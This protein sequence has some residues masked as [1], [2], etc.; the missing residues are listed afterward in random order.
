[1]LHLCMETEK[2]EGTQLTPLNRS[3][4]ESKASVS[5]QETVSMTWPDHREPFLVQLLGNTSFIASFHG[6]VCSSLALKACV[7]LRLNSSLALFFPSKPCPCLSK[8]R[9][10]AHSLPPIPGFCNQ[11]P[12]SLLRSHSSSWGCPCSSSKC[13]SWQRSYR[14]P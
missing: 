12:L 7:C 10:R 14:V 5:P 3:Q 2:E 9:L 1:M 8:D 4:R 13:F 11:S 6:G